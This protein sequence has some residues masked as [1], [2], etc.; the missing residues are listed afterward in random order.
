MTELKIGAYYN[1]FHKWILKF[2]LNYFGTVVGTIMYL[3][4]LTPSL[5][6][7]AW[8]V[9]G[10]VGG[11]AFALGYGLGV[12]ISWSFRG[13][14]EYDFSNNT[15]HIAWT[16]FPP[17]SAVLLVVFLVLY[18]DWQTTIRNLGG[19]E[20][21][22]N[23]L[24]LLMLASS[25]I[26]ALLFVGVGKL[27]RRLF[28]SL[29]RLF[30]KWVPKRVGIAL[31]LIFASLI[32]VWV[33]NGF[34]IDGS[35]AIADNIYSN[36]NESDPEGYEVPP[37]PEHSGSSESLI[38]W[39]TLGFQ[40]KKFVA[41]TSTVE[42]MEQFSAAPAKVPIRI[43]SGVDSADD[44]KERAQLVIDEIRRTNAMDRDVLLVVTPTGTGW[45]EP[46]SIR[47]IEHMYN[48]DIATVAMQYSYLPSWI[49]TL[50]DKSRAQEGGIAL[51]EAVY[52]EWVKLP[53]NERPKL[54]IHGL[55]LG[56]YG[57]QSPFAS[58][59]D[60][61][62]RTDGALFMGTPSFSQPWRK[63]TDNRDEGSPEVRPVVDGGKIAVFGADKEDILDNISKTQ[64]PRVFFQQ[65]PS[66][67]VVWWSPDLIL[68][69]P[70]WIREEAGKGVIEDI[71]WIPFVT[72]FQVS[73]DQVVA[74]EAPDGFGHNYRNTLVLAWSSVVPPD[75]W[76]QEDA[77][78]LQNVIFQVE[79]KGGSNL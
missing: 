3:L 10:L 32:T 52:E 40:G 60:L 38:P 14:F 12:F 77:A 29:Q 70:D 8:L 41:N 69:E 67:G 42:E 49:A 63:L 25:V 4:S 16:L 57:A 26:F 47:A 72:F 28:N 11:I 36:K 55:S 9:Q 7:R 79:G 34:L 24:L 2:N 22:P 56:S 20:H 44:L 50:V 76:T 18:A 59:S 21:Q 37:W 5:M 6:P 48:G 27:V 65:H 73:I 13:L 39:S 31:G 30:D 61:A 23:Y 1:V 19:F 43:Y 15:K 68:H 33:F 58:A 78:R 54:I 51:F 46:N 66:D 17:I 74:G 35:L 64:L 62:A 45:I 53:V 75:G 71:L